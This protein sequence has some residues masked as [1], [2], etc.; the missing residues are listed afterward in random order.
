MSDEL[1]PTLRLLAA[2]MRV[3][4]TRA[5]RSAD[6]QVM[7]H[8]DA[9]RKG[10]RVFRVA[11]PNPEDCL[12][13]LYNA[14]GAIGVDY[15][16]VGADVWS[17]KGGGNPITGREWEIGDMDRIAKNDLGLHRGILGE[18]IGLWGFERG[19]TT[20]TAMMGYDHDRSH[21]RITWSTPE[22]LESSGIGRFPRVAREGFERPDIFA[23]AADLVGPP[24][25]GYDTE[26]LIRK[27]AVSWVLAMPKHYR[28][29]ES[30]KGPPLETKR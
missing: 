20:V 16:V 9:Y 7:H 26:H 12:N 21:S 30:P 1:P 17:A 24:P 6:G 8:V 22:I 13:V 29:I 10:E 28:I 14:P 2:L 19:G 11:V 5:V 18:H 23:L 3:E 25:E 27:C 15:L 4:K